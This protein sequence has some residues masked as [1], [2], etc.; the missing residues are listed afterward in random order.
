MQQTS[1]EK[2]ALLLRT[3][4]EIVGAGRTDTG[5]H[6]RYYV[7][8]FDTVAEITSTID[9]AYHLNAMLPNDIAIIELKKVA[10]DAHARFDAVSREYKY[11][12]E[13]EKNP[14]TR[15]TSWQFYR[16]ISIEAM[17][18]ACKILLQE[19][20][21]TTFAKLNSNNKTNICHV[22]NA[23][24]C[25]TERGAEFTIRADRFLR[26][27]VRAIV[28]TL[29]DVGAGK[30]TV[31]EFNNIVTSRNLARSSASAPAH[32]LFLTDVKYKF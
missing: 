32:G 18:E 29:M 17:N 26:N 28:G 14:F 22:T 15:G 16:S 6:A 21:F 19:R 25:T 31:E 5:V 4:T 3:S 8:H 1:E 27:M 12:V 23:Q 13:F 11:S 2:L 7:A 30:I 10:D 24:W 20:D 9:F